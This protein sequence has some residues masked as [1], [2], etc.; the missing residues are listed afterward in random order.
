MLTLGGRSFCGACGRSLRFFELIPVASFLALGGRCRTCRAKISWQYPL[1]EIV[2][3]LVFLILYRSGLSLFPFLVSSLFFSALIFI[4]VYDLRHKIIPEE[5]V[6][7][8]VTTA[9]L[10]ILLNFFTAGEIKIYDSLAGLILAS[11]L[12]L[13]Y[14]WSGGRLI[15]FGDIKLMFA[16]GTFLGLERGLSAFLLA[17]WV[18]A[19]FSLGLLLISR[20]RILKFTKKSFTMKS[21][22]PFAPFLAIG[23][24]WAFVGAPVIVDLSLF[25]S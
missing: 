15:G 16:I 20:L 17:C 21:E 18:G 4:A 23:A 3:G 24:F 19:A 9:F 11:P 25:F 22:V 6:Y 1:V 2:T 13:I 7:L 10:S 14:F 8:T 5:A 12:A